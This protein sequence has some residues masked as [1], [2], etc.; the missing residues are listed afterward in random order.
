MCIKYG[1]VVFAVDDAHFMDAESWEFVVDLGQDMRSLVVLTVRTSSIGG[2][3]LCPSAKRALNMPTVKHITLGGL[4]LQYMS[5][6]AC[7]LLD[8][9]QIPL[10][11]DT[12]VSVMCM[13]LAYASIH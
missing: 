10:K 11:L 7:H 4:G 12:L 13:R 5:A 6:L 8:V 3:Q 2:L 1:F 9:V